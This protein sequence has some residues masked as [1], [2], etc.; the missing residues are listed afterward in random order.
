MPKRRLFRWPAPRTAG[1]T[2]LAMLFSTIAL[3]IYGGGSF[4][5]SPHRRQKRSFFSHFLTVNAWI[6]LTL[7]PIEQEESNRNQA[8]R[9][10]AD[11]TATYSDLSQ[12]GLVLAATKSDD[13]QWLLDYCKERCVIAA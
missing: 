11:I 13:L 1:L 4:P 10:L 9:E 5:V 6:V 3:F 7:A 8:I 12:V 2:L